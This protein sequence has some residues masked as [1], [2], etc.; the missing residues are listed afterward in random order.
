MLRHH[1]LTT[2]A[3]VLGCIRS[4]HAPRRTLWIYPLS[5]TYTFTPIPPVTASRTLLLII[6]LV[7]RPSQPASVDSPP[8]PACRAFCI[9]LRRDPVSCFYRYPGFL[10]LLLR[11]P[12]AACGCS[13]RTYVRPSLVTSPLYSTLALACQNKSPSI[14]GL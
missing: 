7:S 6:R 11:R 14:N 4:P 1:V 13:P 8:L 3:T 5:C 2:L 12:H 10:P 9:C